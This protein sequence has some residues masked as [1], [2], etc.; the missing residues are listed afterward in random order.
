MF[1]KEK[2]DIKNILNF[3]DWENIKPHQIIKLIEL[4][5]EIDNETFEKILKQIPS[6]VENNKAI[7]DGLIKVVNNSKEMSTDTKE[8]YKQMINAIK[9]MVNKGVNSEELN[10]KL[11][12][13]MDKIRE[14]IKELDKNDKEQSNRQLGELIKFGEKALIVLAVGIG[15][16]FAVKKNFKI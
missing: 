9:E 14:D 15:A 2:V 13:L 6:L 10:N 16:R 7:I 11:I 4:S 8:V 5:P 3:E 12:E 1:K